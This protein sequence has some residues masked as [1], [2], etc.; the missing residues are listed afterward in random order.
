MAM[1]IRDGVLVVICSWPLGLRA[2]VV[3]VIVLFTMVLTASAIALL[4]ILRSEKKPKQDPQNPP[5]HSPLS[6]GAV[7]TFG[8]LFLSLSVTS[9]DF[10]SRVRYRALGDPLVSSWLL[11]L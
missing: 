9:L 7:L 8:V 6:L 3:P 4:V 11:L 1:I 2:S 10:L 5:L